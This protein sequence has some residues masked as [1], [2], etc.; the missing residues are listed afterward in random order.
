MMEDTQVFQQTEIVIDEN[1]LSIPFTVQNFY[2]TFDKYELYYSAE[3]LKLIKEY[4]NK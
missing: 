2:S 1:E 3:D 4:I